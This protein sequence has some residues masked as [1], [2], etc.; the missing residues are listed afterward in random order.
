MLIESVLEEGM[1]L[2]LLEDNFYYLINYIEEVESEEDIIFDHLN[3]QG[4][5]ETLINV[6]E[7]K[8][9]FYEDEEHHRSL[10]VYDLG[11][12]LDGGINP[13]DTDIPMG[14]WNSWCSLVYYIDNFANTVLNEIFQKTHFYFCYKSEEYFIREVKSKGWFKNHRTPNEKI[15]VEYKLSKRLYRKYMQ[16]IFLELYDGL[17]ELNGKRPQNNDY[18][19]SVVKKVISEID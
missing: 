18:V 7:F 12:G 11:P 9:S 19:D 16:R 15:D 14:R 17:L 10:F 8:L 13:E 1:E 5:F 3:Y 6:L 4:C 2:A